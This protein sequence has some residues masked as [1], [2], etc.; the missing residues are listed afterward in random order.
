MTSDRD[1]C[2]E[3]DCRQHYAKKY[4][5]PVHCDLRPSSAD[6]VSFGLTRRNYLAGH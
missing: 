1:S 2:V 5:K 4:P 6:K 3:R